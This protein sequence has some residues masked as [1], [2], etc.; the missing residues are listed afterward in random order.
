MKILLQDD[1]ISFEIT[2]AK[3]KAK[4][5]KAAKKAELV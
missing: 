2:A 4:S 5:G 3:P 1:K